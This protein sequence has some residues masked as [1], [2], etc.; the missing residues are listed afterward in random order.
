[1]LKELATTVDHRTPLY[2]VL[3]I[4]EALFHETYRTFKGKLV[5]RDNWTM[6]KQAREL[7]LPISRILGT[8]GGYEEWRDEV[9]EIRKKSGVYKEGDNEILRRLG[10]ELIENLTDYHFPVVTLQSRT[11]VEAVCMIFETLN[12]TGVKLSVFDLSVARLY[13]SDIKLRDA[14]EEARS[15]STLFNEYWIDPYYLLQVVALRCTR[16]GMGECKRG[17]VLKLEAEDY[18]KYWKTS[19]E[20]FAEGLKILRENCGVLTPDWLPYATFLV[21][22]A[23]IIADTKESHHGYEI[24]GWKDK[25]QR[26]FW[27]ST[28]AQSYENAANSVSKNHYVEIKKWLEGGIKPQFLNEAQKALDTIDLQ[29]ITPRQRA[30][31]KG[32]MC[33]ILRK[34]IKDFYKAETITPS[35]ILSGEVNDHH[36]FPKA[37]FGKGEWGEIIDSIPN[38]TLIDERSNKIIRDK[39]PSDYIPILQQECQPKTLN[40]IFGQHL[41]PIGE[42]SPTWNDDLPLFLKYR[43]G[44]LLKEA[45]ELAGGSDI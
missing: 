3:D 9:V 22:F 27:A 35:K 11:P 7:V 1:M 45:K 23:A 31:Y 28:F 37:V 17:T 25:L 16:K 12:R 33:V 34:G 6:E 4:E 2:E 10:K 39:K 30:R 29:D 14:W 36:I 38:R 15:E 41:I 5:E 26:W 19:V 21:P 44:I 42:G 32:L 24:A 18:H 8:H 43:T 20:G 40:E 13:A